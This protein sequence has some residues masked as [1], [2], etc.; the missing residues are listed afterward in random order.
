MRKLNVER[1]TCKRHSLI[2]GSGELG[3]E[4]PPRSRPQRVSV[5]P[6]RTVVRNS[7]AHVWTGVAMKTTTSLGVIERKPS[8][9]LFL[10]ATRTSLSSWRP[11]VLVMF[12]SYKL[13][14]QPPFAQMKPV[15]ANGSKAAQLTMTT[16]ARW[17]QRRH[18]AGPPL[19]REG[20]TI[21]RHAR[22][23]E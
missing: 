17:N 10:N 23:M 16:S 8:S 11:L 20:H 18:R 5:H 14:P 21:S 15:A 3:D 9:C 7:R 1:G 6:A 19:N 4:K 22:R 2:I 12:Q 13:R